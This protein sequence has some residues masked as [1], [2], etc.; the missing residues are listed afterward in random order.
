MKKGV[1]LIFTGIIGAAALYDYQ[2]TQGTKKDSLKSS[3]KKTKK[4]KKKAKLQARQKDKKVLCYINGQYWDTKEE[5]NKFVDR[6]PSSDKGFQEKGKLFEASFDEIK[7]HLDE[8]YI[9]AN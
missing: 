5:V 1:L 4:G 6:I 9:W 3:N 7:S 2:S 8:N